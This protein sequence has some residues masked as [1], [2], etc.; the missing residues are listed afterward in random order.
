MSIMR[1][2][3]D[4]RYKKTSGL[5][6]VALS[7][8]CV[9][10]AMLCMCCFITGTHKVPRSNSPVTPMCTVQNNGTSV[11]TAT[12]ANEIT[13]DDIESAVT[14]ATTSSNTII[15][16]YAIKIDFPIHIFRKISKPHS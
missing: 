14:A 8:V 13:V 1:I 15:L 10:T 7:Y 16:P 6:W 3:I 2:S 12:V 9:M 11:S 5:T 4:F